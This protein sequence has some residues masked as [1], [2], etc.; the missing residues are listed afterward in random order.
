MSSCSRCRWS[1]LA[2][3]FQ[4]RSSHLAIGIGACVVASANDPATP[5]FLPTVSFLGVLSFTPAIA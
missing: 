2:C 1:A 5:Y 3:T 4:S